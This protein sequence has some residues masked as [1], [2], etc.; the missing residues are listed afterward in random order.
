LI[1]DT[2]QAKIPD[3]EQ[4]RVTPSWQG[5]R[6]STAHEKERHYSPEAFTLQ[7]DFV[8]FFGGACDLA[9]SFMLIGLARPSHRSGMPNSRGSAE[10]KSL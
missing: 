2:L 8:E 6:T 1:G 4:K 3:G 7:S 5:S 9:T 10:T